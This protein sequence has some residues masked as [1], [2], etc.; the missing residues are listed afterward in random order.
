VLGTPASEAPGAGAPS[1]VDGAQE[2]TLC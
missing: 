2:S 1:P